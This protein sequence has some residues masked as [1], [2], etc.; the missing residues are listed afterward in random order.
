M[1]TMPWHGQ[2]QQLAAGGYPCDHAEHRVLRVDEPAAARRWLARVLAYGWPTAAGAQHPHFGVDL[3]FTF[4]GLQAMHAPD[5]LLQV[6]RER[7]PAYA[8]GAPPRATQRLGDFGPSAPAQW[9]V[10]FALDR[11]HVVVSVHDD[12]VADIEDSFAK[13]QQLDADAG[14]YGWDGEGMRTAQLTKDA[15]PNSKRLLRR[16]H[17]GFRDNITN[18]HAVEPAQKN[19]DQGQHAAGELLL[20]WAND[21]GYNRW[22]G[23]SGPPAAT[24][25][26]F[27]NAS[28]GVLR[29]IE[30]DV[31]GFERDL[32]QRAQVMSAKHPGITTDYLKAKMCGRWP[33][34]AVVGAQDGF[35]PPQQQGDVPSAFPKYDDA[36][37]SG[38]PFGSHVR[39]CNPRHDDLRPPQARVLFRRGMPY[40]PL[41]AGKD[42]G[43]SRGLAGFFFCA[44]IEDQFETLM[45][46]WVEKM[47]MVQGSAGRSKDPLV[48]HHTEPDAK[49]V[50]PRAGGQPIELTGLAS[51][52]TTRGTLYALYPSRAALAQLAAV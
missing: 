10:E 38:C 50:V 40:G 27:L 8:E 39:R 25:A 11:A 2:A 51:Y 41:Y 20:G 42:D 35:T 17:F 19:A 43:E 52:L 32:A 33:D 34:G 21:A 49:F 47:P 31:H 48:G 14:L 5:R 13:L 4:R 1:S 9:D 15:I 30:Q 12:S 37:G 24:Q 23:D 22:G 26:F 29:R 7:A 46:E 44:S 3:G 6:L 36:D 18:A 28:F 45:S 16:V